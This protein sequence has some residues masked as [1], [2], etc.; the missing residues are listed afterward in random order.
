M[1]ENILLVIIVL[2]FENAGE[3][4][5]EIFKALVMLE[6]MSLL[7][8]GSFFL[9]SSIGSRELWFVRCGNGMFVCVVYSSLLLVSWKCLGLNER[10]LLK[11]WHIRLL[12]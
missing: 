8:V 3:Y 5:F 11:N 6:H 7:C 4:L 2:P 9:I 10:G 12:R 1:Q